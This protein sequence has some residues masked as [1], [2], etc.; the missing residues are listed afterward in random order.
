MSFNHARSPTTKVHRKRNSVDVLQLMSTVPSRQ[1][2]VKAKYKG[3]SSS[4]PIEHLSLALRIISEFCELL[5][6][7]LV[8][9]LGAWAV[10]SLNLGE[11]THKMGQCVYAFSSLGLHAWLYASKRSLFNTG[12]TRDNSLCDPKL[13]FWIFFMYVSRMFVMTPRHRHILSAGVFFLLQIILK[14]VTYHHL[15]RSKTTEL[16]LILE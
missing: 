13:L 4:P 1:L 5:F 3:S 11:E 6:T 7:E 8:W 15:T 14:T 9:L 12:H 10:S 2:W 16:I